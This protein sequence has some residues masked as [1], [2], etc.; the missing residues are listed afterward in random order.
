[1]KKNA[2]SYEW[3]DR[4]DFTAPTVLLSSKLVHQLPRN[5]KD[6]WS[7][8]RTMFPD[9]IAVTEASRVGFNRARTQAVVLLGFATV[10]LGGEGEYVLLEKQGGRWSVVHRLRAWLS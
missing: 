5:P 3:E 9:L 8:L 4:F 7:Q 1:M 2:I 6:Y 10:P